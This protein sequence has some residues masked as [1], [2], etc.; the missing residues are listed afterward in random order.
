MDID[1]LP[2]GFKEWVAATVSKT[3][4]AFHGA[5]LSAIILVMILQLWG[6]KNGS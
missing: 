2:G 1:D 6:G 5:L 4:I 3:L